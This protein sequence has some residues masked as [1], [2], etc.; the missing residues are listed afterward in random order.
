MTIIRIK[1][2]SGYST[3]VEH[4]PLDRE[5]MGLIPAGYWAFSHLYAISSVSLNRSLE[6]VHHY[7]FFYF[8]MKAKLY[9]FG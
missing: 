8:K 7:C 3:A 1:Q 5:V 4:T 9:S 2:G 6:M